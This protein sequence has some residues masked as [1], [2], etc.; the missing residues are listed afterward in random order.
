MDEETIVANDIALMPKAG[1][2][3]SPGNKNVQS[4]I[5]FARME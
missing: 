5:Q 3:L 1:A 4:G 2:F